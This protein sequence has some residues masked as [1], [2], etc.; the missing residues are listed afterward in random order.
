MARPLDDIC[1]Y[2]CNFPDEITIDITAKDLLNR[3]VTFLILFETVQEALQSQPFIQLII[4]ITFVLEE[5][6]I[7]KHIILNIYNMFFL[8]Q[9]MK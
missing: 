8:Y 7:S 4:N 2:Y 6:C 9:I 5:K 3:D 1:R